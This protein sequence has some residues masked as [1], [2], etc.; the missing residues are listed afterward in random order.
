MWVFLLVTFGASWLAAT[1][2]WVSGSPLGSPPVLV[3]AVIMMMT[4]S[5]GVVAVWRL[6]HRGTPFRQWARQTGLTLG[7]SRARTGKLVAAAWLGESVHGSES[8]Q[9]VRGE[10]RRAGPPSWRSRPARRARRR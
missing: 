4:P 10:R 2:V 7:P 8:V 9:R 3:T 6:V 5:L 1:P